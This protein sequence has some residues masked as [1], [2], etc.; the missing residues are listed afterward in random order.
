MIN[1]MWQGVYPAVTTKFKAD[2]SLDFQLMKKHF[3]AQIEAGV[4]GLVVV[5]SLGENSTLSLN[6]KQ[7]VL[8]TAVAASNGRVPVIA[9]LAEG[10]TADAQRFAQLTSDNGGNGIMILPPMRYKSDRRETLAYF[11]SIAKASELP[12]MIY[13]NPIDY[14]VDVT[15]EMFA[16]LIDEEKIVAIKESSRDVRRITDLINLVNSR[17]QIFCG[18]DDIAL[19]CLV[20]GANGWLAGLACAFPRET[21]MIYNLQKSGKLKEALDLYRWFMPLLHLDVS[22]KLV[23]NIKL[24]EAMVEIGNEYVRP[25]RLPLAGEERKNVI[26]IIQE[27][28]DSKLELSRLII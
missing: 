28:L 20:L 6:E 26:K 10:N 25:P 21:V 9:T 4:H 5:G 16:E 23:Q 3:I 18:V 27:A 1:P 24:A 22:T 8:K 7:E 17:Y 15:P 11:R 12:I 14:G 13:N 19:E 2:F